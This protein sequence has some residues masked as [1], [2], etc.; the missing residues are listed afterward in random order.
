MKFAIDLVPG[1]IPVSMALYRMSASELRELKNQLGDLLEKKFIISNVPP[2]G[3]PVLLVK[4]K[5]GSMQLCVDYRQLNEVTIKNK[6]PLPSIG[7]L[8]DQL[9]GACMFSKIYLRSG[10]HQIR[11]KD[12]DC[13][14]PF[15]RLDN[16]FLESCILIIIILLLGVG[17][18]CTL[19]LG[20]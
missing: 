9:V 15:F 16:L 11:V 6:C 3:A 13:N 4:K 8:M 18:I 1:T 10:C 5:D 7:D 2:W 20:V 12:E 14:T 17:R 19:E